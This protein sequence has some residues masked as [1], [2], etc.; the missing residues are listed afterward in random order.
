MTDEVKN[1]KE[2]AKTAY[3]R[4]GNPLVL[5]ADESPVCEHNKK[6][7]RFDSPCIMQ[8]DVMYTSDNSR[9]TEYHPVYYVDKKRGNSWAVFTAHDIKLALNR[10]KSVVK[11][12][13]VK[14]TYTGA[15]QT[16][17]DELNKRLEILEIQNA[18]LSKQ[19]ET[20]HDNKADIVT[21]RNTN[22]VLDSNNRILKD[23]WSE[24][25]NMNEELT[26]RYETAEE[27]LRISDA[28]RKSATD[29]VDASVLEI[30]QLRSSYDRDIEE[31]VNRGVEKREA[32]YAADK[33]IP[34]S[35]PK[36]KSRFCGWLPW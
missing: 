23:K 36:P 3:P 1:T 10:G 9:Q 32:Q 11:D 20:W 2:Y 22:G 28:L 19:S 7:L 26:T 24:C 34:P 16:G 5:P 18:E 17:T 27:E 33:P 12:K 30:A 21:L 6:L 4:G 29:A 31:A 8:G 13:E 35:K 14:L 15:D 25:I